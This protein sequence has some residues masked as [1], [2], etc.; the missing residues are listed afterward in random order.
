MVML[1]RLYI[2]KRSITHLVMFFTIG[3]GITTSIGTLLDNFPIKGPW[4]L[5]YVGN[6]I[7]ITFLLATALAGPIEDR[8]KKS[9]IRFRSAF[10]RAEFYKDLF[11]HDISNILQN[12]KTSLELVSQWH[13]LDDKK[14]DIDNIFNIMDEQVTRGSKLVNNIRK[15]S[16]VEEEEINLRKV[17]II[18]CLDLSTNF[19]IE[20]YPK[21]D[22]T[23]Q[24]NYEPKERFVNANELLLDVFEN[25]LMNAVKYNDKSSI[26]ISID[27]ANIK[28]NDLKYLKIEFKDNG[29]GIP[30]EMKDAVFKSVIKDRDR[31][32]GMGLG[33]LLVK[34][35]IDNYNGEIWVE[36]NVKGDY[37]KGS[38]F[39]LLI[40][41]VN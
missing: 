32:K 12:V 2:K 25:I 30:D 4:E 34:R 14:E 24:K 38:N 26:K 3:S 11:A 16:Q 23:I 19:I 17:N 27:I 20:S 22:I 40:P 36:D 13:G 15:F 37:T 28:Q 33:L 10:N 31:V 7:T 35:I 41:K 21:K 8:I 6:I 1:L 29:I 5:S 18:N 39:I 9:E